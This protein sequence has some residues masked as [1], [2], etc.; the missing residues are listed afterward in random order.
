MI[1]KMMNFKNNNNNDNDDICNICESTSIVFDKK[2]NKNICLD[3]NKNNNKNDKIIKKIEDFKNL[4]LNY[5]YDDKIDYEESFREI[6]NKID[7]FT[8]DE[9]KIKSHLLTKFSEIEDLYMEACDETSENFIDQINQYNYI[10]TIVRS[11]YNYGF[12]K[13]S[14]VQS[15]GILPILERRD[16]IIQAQSGSGKTATFLTAAMTKVDPT[17]NKMQVLIITH[18]R[19]LAQ[20][21]FLVANSLF[22]SKET[23]VRFALHTGGIRSDCYSNSDNYLK[24][25][26]TN[27]HCHYDEQI[28]I[29]TPGRINDLLNS[30]NKMPPRLN[31]KYLSL[32]LLDEADQLLSQGFVESIKDLLKN[33]I[34]DTVQIAIFSATM[35]NDIIDLTKNFMRN[36]IQVLIR[37]KSVNLEGIKQFYINCEQEKFKS[38][39]L[40]D[41]LP[42]F[43]N[44]IGIIFVN[45]KE[46]LNNLRDFMIHN[47]IN[48]LY[49]S[50]E[51]TQ[52]ERYKTM[53]TFKNDRKYRL[54]LSTDLTARGID[55]HQV[56]L[57]VNY[58]IPLK[59]ETYIHRVGRTGR[60]GKTGKA[61]NLV[62]ND[63]HF[64]LKEYSEKYAIKM[65]EITE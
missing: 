43:D 25:D 4:K 5:K 20:Q 2:T 21:I 31:T 52:I 16:C 48:I 59:S 22:K 42:R 45:S 23:G 37:E 27:E 13:P 62:T 47:K 15:L 28:I 58:D 57:V 10:V 7:V 14:Y 49:I 17:I 46:T 12:Q 11:I 40:L 54:L 19:E 36:T 55:I 26:I 9:Y 34:H 60:F 39:I 24:K 33:H 18:A 3:C 53:E 35:P 63:D 6:Q 50:S 44:D 56:S 51:M 41:I 1:N 65:T 32:L 38:E 8:N 64:K 61:I 30:K 29:C